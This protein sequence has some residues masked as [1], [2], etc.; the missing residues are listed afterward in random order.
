MKNINPTQTAAWQ[1]LQKHFDEMKDVTIAD[2]F[3]KDGDR[4]SKFSAT[5]DDQMLVDYSKNRITEETLAKL[6]DLAKE[7]DLA[8]AIKSM[9]SGEK[10]NRTENR[11]VLHV[12]L[13]NRSNTPILVDGKDVMP[14]VNAVLEKMKTFSEAIISGEWKGYTGK[15]ITDV[16]NIGIGGSD[17]GPYMVTEAL[18]PYKNHLNMHF[19]SNVD[20][21]HIAEV[22]KKVNPE[23]TLFLVASKT[24]TTQETMTN[25]HSA[26]DWFLKAAGDEKHVAKHFAALSTNTKAV[27]EFG[28]DTANMFEFWDWVGGR[29]SLWSAIGLSIV[30]SIGF[31]NFVEL[32][33]GAHAMDKHFSTTPA[34]KNLPVLLALIGIW[35]NNF[36]G[37]ETEAIL[38]YDQYMHRFAAYFQQGNMESNGKYVDR[39]G[40]VVDYQTGPI[41]WG[42][43]GTNGQHAFYQLIHQGTKMVPC[44][45]IAPAIT[46]NPLS[47][48][49]QK[50]LSNFF[51]QTEALAFGKSREVVEQEYRDQGKDPATLDYVVPF[52]VFEGNRPTNSILLRE[53]TPFSLGALIA[54]YEHKIFTQGVILNIFTFDQWGVELGKQLANRILPELKD[55]KEISSHDSSTNGLINRYKAWR[56]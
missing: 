4:F 39:N 23:T 21:T 46:H 18:R 48:H 54:L 17:L 14:E 28:I 45:F 42:E 55:D 12:A 30:L 6:Q 9:F 49:H 53:I 44:D 35:Y 51:A 16:V 36:F 40:N 15:A 19:V 34:E 25:A 10:I 43:P 26:R 1:A 38:P 20:G 8:G 5:F 33:S 29:Y 11:A 47:D 50:L 2:L 56:D 7:C 52:K 31:D 32:L 22:L 27:G 13:R 41:I 3:A 24:F 37:A